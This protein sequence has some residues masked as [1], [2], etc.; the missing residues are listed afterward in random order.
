MHYD[1]HDFVT[2]EE[3]IRQTAKFGFDGFDVL[4]DSPH[5]DPKNPLK[6]T[7]TVPRPPTMKLVGS[8]IGGYSAKAVLIA[9]LAAQELRAFMARGHIVPGGIIFLAGLARKLK[10][11][12]ENHRPPV[13]TESRLCAVEYLPTTLTH[14]WIECDWNVGDR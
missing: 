8:R 10:L 2:L 3:A 1:L 12:S 4:A 6:C 14:L 9:V 11:L 7:A 5:F 13:H